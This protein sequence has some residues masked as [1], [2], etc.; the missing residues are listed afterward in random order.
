MINKMKEIWNK[1]KI[2]L[3]EISAVNL[4]FIDIFK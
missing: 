2:I 1:K 3:A 4:E